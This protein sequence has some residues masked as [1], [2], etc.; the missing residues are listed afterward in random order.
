MRLQII[1]ALLRPLIEAAINLL[2]M[3]DDN[4]TGF[5]DEAAEGLQYALERLL[6][7]TS[8][9]VMLFAICSG[10]VLAQADRFRISIHYNRTDFPFVEREHD[11]TENVDGATAEADVRLFNA[12]GLRGSIAYNVK[13]M[14][15]AIV[16]PDYF[17]GMNVVDLRRDVWTHSGLAQLGY[18]VKDAFEP[19]VAFGYGT[20]KIHTDAPRQIVRTFRLGVN[21]P[22]NKKSHF[23]VKGYYDFETPYGQLPSGFVN[24][25]TSTLG[26]G[27]GFRF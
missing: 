22:F 23:L 10:T 7:Y 26:I 14:R 13:L 25:D 18:T 2:R 16:Y 24:P 9:I 8:A 1:L 17:D 20:R 11:Y 15:Y 21:I 12:G 19:F 6:K 4:S 3:K 27:V 5:D